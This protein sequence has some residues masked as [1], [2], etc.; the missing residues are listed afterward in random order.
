[1]LDDA[2]VEGLVEHREGVVNGVRLHWVEAGDGPL[3]VLVHGFPEFWWSWRHQIPA[4]VAAG[5]RVVAV[6]LRGYNRSGRPAGLRAYRSTVVAADVAALVRACGAGPARLVGHDWGGIAAWLVAASD[7]RVVDRL[8]VVNAP[9]PLAYRRGLRRPTQALRSAYVALFQLPAAPE[10]ALGARRCAGLRRLL[11]TAAAPGT[12]T[13]DD[14]ER[15]AEAFSQPGALT[16][17]LAYYRALRLPP[18]RPV[19]AER[20][21]VVRA[22]V[23]V[24]W[25]RRDPA[26]SPALADPGDDLAPDCRV[27]MIDAGHFVHAEA[28]AR[29]NALVTGFLAQ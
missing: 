11:T 12:F 25:G 16:A 27:E 2:D 19:P 23:L 5:F 26:L 9:H 3:V 18:Y 10:L 14:L 6:D 22:P 1:M 28:P 4:L 20:S 7:P 24:V 29:V 17:A 21:G 8:V 13:D 15:Y